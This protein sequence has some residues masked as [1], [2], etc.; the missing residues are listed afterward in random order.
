MAQER[1]DRKAGDKLIPAGGE[2][3]GNT[4]LSN[5]GDAGKT[6]PG[7]APTL[8]GRRRRG[9]RRIMGR[10]NID[11]GDSGVIVAP[12]VEGTGGV[13]MEEG[14]EDGADEVVMS[15]DEEG[16]SRIKTLRFRNEFPGDVLSSCATLV[17]RFTTVFGIPAVAVNGFRDDKGRYQ[18]SHLGPRQSASALK[19]GVIVIGI[20]DA[21]CFE[22]I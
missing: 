14:V 8:V 16:F 3:V 19:G 22:E 13:G 20:V 4:I 11:N 6:V 12:A 17:I 15:D 9:V 18:R 21:T 2:E 10:S 5:E 7:G 1:L